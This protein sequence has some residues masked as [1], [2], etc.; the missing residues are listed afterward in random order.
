MKKPVFL[1]SLIYLLWGTFGLLTAQ[2]LDFDTSLTFNS[3]PKI[4][5]KVNKI[6]DENG[7]LIGY[8][9]TYVWSYSNGSFSREFTIHPDSLFKQFTPWFNEQLNGDFFEP[10]SHKIFNDSTLYFNFFNDDH[11]F[12]QWRNEIFDVQK[13]MEKMDSLKQIFFQQFFN[14]EKNHISSP[15]VSGRQ[16]N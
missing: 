5:I 12:D 10:F 14:E 16:A 1:F 3:K 9:S 8:D 15:D 7:N 11:F 4:E 13:E 2:T 6:Y